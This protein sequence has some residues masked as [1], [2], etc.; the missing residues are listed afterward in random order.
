MTQASYRLEFT[1]QAQKDIAKLSPKLKAKL[2]DIL[3]HKI[4][5]NP[6]SGK[7]LLGQLAG[8]YSVW[9][10]Y[11]DR[12]VYRIEDDRC[13]VLIVRARTHYGW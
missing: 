5:I 1:R 10:S 6:Q 9:L 12:I 2:K 11:Q 3:R 4:S 8:F 7:P 13:V